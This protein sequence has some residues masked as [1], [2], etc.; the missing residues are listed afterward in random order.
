MRFLQPETLAEAVDLLGEDPDARTIVAGGTA[1]VRQLHEGTIAPDLL[2]SLARVPNLDSIWLSDGVLHLG[3]LSLMRHVAE[4]VAVKQHFPALARA[5]EV[6]GSVRIRNQATLGG[7]LA[8]AD[9]ATDPPAV[10]LALNA[11]VN[12]AGS[13]GERGIPLGNFIRGAFVTALMPGEIITSVS[14][15]LLPL[16]TRMTYLKFKRGS[17]PDRPCV[18]VAAVAAF[19][20][21]KC[22]DLRV[23]VGAASPTPRRL[24]Q[25]EVLAENQR[26]TDELIADIARGYANDIEPLD[27]LRGS[28]WYH[29][30][31]IRVHVR[32]GLEALRDGGR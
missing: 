11:V 28:A 20:G 23:S 6:V 25:V 14:I 9:Y 29:T 15:P 10:L 2:V 21:D 3:A 32:R 19:D 30:Q 24:P 1:L 7:N 4:S 31:M 26:L 22:S 16:G 12:V 17:S 8:E 18:S 13:G 27:D 5:C